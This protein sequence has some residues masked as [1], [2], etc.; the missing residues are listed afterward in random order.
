MSKFSIYLF[1]F[2]KIRSQ[3]D[4]LFDQNEKTISILEQ[5]EINKTNIL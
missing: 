5:I 1:D 4:T 2:A 3:N